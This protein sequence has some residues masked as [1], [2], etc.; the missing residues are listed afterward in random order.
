MKI[1]ILTNFQDLN[2][3]YSLTGIVIDQCAMLMKYGHEVHLLVSE[4]YNPKF[5]DYLYSRVDKDNPEFTLAKITPFGHLHDYTSMISWKP[6][7][8]YLSVQTGEALVEYF[9]ANEIGIAF[10]HDWIFTGW[11]LPYGGGVR[12]ASVLLPQVAWLHWVHSVPSVMRDWWK[13]NFYGPQH[14]IVFPNKTEARRVAE[15]FRT[16]ENNVY[17]IGHIK[18]MRHWY[19]MDSETIRFINDHPA[20]MSAEMVQIYPASSDRL[21]A[22]GI[23]KVAKIFAFW[24]KHRITGCLVIANQW[25]T[26]RARKEDLVKYNKIA[27]RAGLEPGVD[28]IFTSEWD[29]KYATGIPSQM[30]RELQHLQNVFIFPTMEESFGLV[31]PEAVFSGCL[32]V[33][34]ASLTMMREVNGNRGLYFDFGSFHNNFDPGQGWDA[35]LE[36]VAM[37]IYNK[38]QMD[39]AASAKS[40][41]RQRYN[42]DHLYNHRYLP[43]MHDVLR[44][45]R[46][47]TRTPEEI[48]EVEEAMKKYSDEYHDI[49]RKKNVKAVPDA[50]I[51]KETPDEE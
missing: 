10:T 28:F 42:M 26:G 33:F 6:E 21:S 25:A 31:G 44:I 29:E 17:D 3:G 7:H 15:Q 24:K 18:D 30:L 16:V 45:S 41:A 19:D 11:N 46:A 47:C 32:P 23:D 22:K 8:Q 13:L 38:Y 36:A 49:Q 37:T 20:L 50:G 12:F 51:K 14:R 40:F 39:S 5:N 34:N 1:A 27:K 48:K 4:K 35:Y 43:C 9:K 2:P